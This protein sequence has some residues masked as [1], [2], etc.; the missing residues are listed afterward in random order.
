MIR[1]QVRV[2]VRPPRLPAANFWLSGPRWRRA[3]ALAR[4]TLPPIAGRPLARRHVL[5]Y[6]QAEDVRELV[7]EPLRFDVFAE[8]VDPR[9]RLG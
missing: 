6:D 7:L 4:V 3:F 1:G 9:E 8:W 5:V 2:A